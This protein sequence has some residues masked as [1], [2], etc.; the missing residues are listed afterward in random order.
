MARDGAAAAKP[1]G[2]QE[3][4]TPLT[5]TFMVARGRPKPRER[6]L[7]SFWCGVRAPGGPPKSAGQK[8][9]ERSTRRSAPTL[10]GKT[11]NMLPGVSNIRE[12]RCKDGSIMRDRQGQTVWE[13]R[14][15]VGRDP[16]T[17]PITERMR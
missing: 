2:R 4:P 14:V 16:V 8:A 9:T 17:N 15:Y 5:S 1:E 12:R 3:A 13:V 7:L 6:S 10:T 11:T